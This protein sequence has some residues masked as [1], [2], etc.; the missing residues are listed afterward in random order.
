[1][2]NFEATLNKINKRVR[3]GYKKKKVE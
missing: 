2:S 1:L 3:V